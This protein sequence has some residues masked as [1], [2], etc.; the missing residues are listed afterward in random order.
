[1]IH[2][3][4]L[5][6][7]VVLSV[8]FDAFGLHFTELSNGGVLVPVASALLLP[9]AEYHR[10]ANEITQARV[11]FERYQ[12]QIREL[13]ASVGQ[14]GITLSDFGIAIVNFGHAIQQVGALFVSVFD[15]EDLVPVEGDENSAVQQEHIEALMDVIREGDKA[16]YLELAKILGVRQD[17]YEELWVGARKRMGIKE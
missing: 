6:L 13:Q 17:K 15:D 1:M 14:F 12:A 4:Q 2:R 10:I 7:P 9:T 16:K 8:E 5:I 3:P 11:R